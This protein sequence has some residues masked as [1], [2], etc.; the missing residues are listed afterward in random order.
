M[1]VTI[2][3][4]IRNADYNLRNNMPLALPI[5]RNQLRNAVVFLEK[6]YGLGE[7]IDQLLEKYPNP[8]F[9]PEVSDVQA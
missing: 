6:G 4:A 8:E 3:D 5:A 2:L 7:N 9:A 1:S